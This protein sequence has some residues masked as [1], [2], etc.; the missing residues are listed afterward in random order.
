MIMKFNRFFDRIFV[1]NL[2][3]RT[4]RRTEVAQELERVDMPLQAGAVEIFPAIRPQEAAPFK[5]I[6]TKGCFLSHLSVLKM[7]QE[8]N[9]SNVLVLEDDIQFTPEFTSYETALVD[10]L[11]HQDWDVVQFGYYR[12][13]MPK[14]PDERLPSLAA[15]SGEAIGAH[16]YAVNGKILGQLVTFLESLLA[17][18]VG[19]R[20]HGPMPIDGAINIFQRRYPQINR[21]IAVPLV[22][23]QR[24]SAS[25]I[26][27]R[28]FDRIWGVRFAVRLARKVPGLRRT[29]RF[30]K[31]QCLAVLGR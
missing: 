30:A 13:E 2:P 28:W 14:Q 21:L 15:F 5:S 29:A 27:P 3:E 18:P 12:V 10:A 8:Q 17:G 11:K 4:D 26:T 6:G 24:S 19:D 16:C 31:K 1:I 9:L 25:D 23:V 7:A 20:L 22:A